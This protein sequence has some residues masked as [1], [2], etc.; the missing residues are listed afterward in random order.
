LG[1]HFE[2]RDTLAIGWKPVFMAA[3]RITAER[4]DVEGGV[5]IEDLVQLLRHP[6]TFLDALVVWNASKIKIFGSLREI[7]RA[8]ELE[9]GKY[10]VL[11]RVAMERVFGLRWRRGGRCSGRGGWGAGHGLR[12]GRGTKGEQRAYEPG[13]RKKVPPP[14]GPRTKFS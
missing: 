5:A 3:F 7:R 12:V 6:R 4:G 2:G 14:H 9:K 8:A 13:K 1:S 11:R 10:S